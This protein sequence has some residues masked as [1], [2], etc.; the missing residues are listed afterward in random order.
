MHGV[1]SGA[2]LVRISA[3]FTRFKKRLHECRQATSKTTNSMIEIH[4]IVDEFKEMNETHE[5][6]V[7]PHLKETEENDKV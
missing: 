1:Q 3:L 6:A 2:N 7:E 4:W 5:K